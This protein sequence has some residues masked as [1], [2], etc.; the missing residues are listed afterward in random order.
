MTDIITSVFT[1]F[2]AETGILDTITENQIFLMNVLFVLGIASIVLGF[3]LYRA[4]F[5]AA[6][7]CAVAFCSCIIMRDI[8]DW[9]TIT[10]TFAVVGTALGFFSYS[11][12]RV[13]GMALSGFAIGALVFSGTH[14]L[15]LAVMLGVGAAVLVIYFSVIT[16]AF[17]TSLGGSF[18]AMEGAIAKGFLSAGQVWLIVP[19]VVIGFALQMLI[20]KNQ[21]LFPV[22]CP[23]RVSYWL[24]QRKKAK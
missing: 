6:M 21:K 11:W 7:F 24:E 20:N 22:T 12:P 13:G 15:W 18:L 9:G 2:A 23:P 10:T 3:L 4:V 1:V 14:R 16:I 17:A 8:T 5:A 19:A